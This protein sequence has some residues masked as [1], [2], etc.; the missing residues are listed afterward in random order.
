MF[1]LFAHLLLLAPLHLALLQILLL[2]HEALVLTVRLLHLPLLL[3]LHL[4]LAL[5]LL[6]LLVLQKTL[7]LAR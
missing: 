2:A 7:L 3:V 6:R 1:H 5:P 4:A